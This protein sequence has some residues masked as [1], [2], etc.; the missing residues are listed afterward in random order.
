M[1]QTKPT[2]VPVLIIGA[3]PAGLS[4]AITLKKARPDL[5]VVV[6]DKAAGPG[7]HN[8]SGAVVEPAALG[9]LLDPVVPDWKDSDKAREVLVG[10]VEH[11]DLMFLLGEKRAFKILP[12]VKMAKA[13]GLGFGQLAH[14]GDFIC[15]ISKLTA[16]LHEIAVSAGVEVLHGFAAEDILWDEATH[17]ATGVTLVDQG[18]D[19]EGHGQPNYLPGETIT[20]DVILIAEGCDGLVAEKFIQKAGQIPPEDY[21]NYHKSCQEVEKSCRR[22]VSFRQK[23]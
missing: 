7:H 11:D 9:K 5:D 12:A 19:K 20:A 17:T 13:F 4:A 15:S 18:V 8:L 16:W 3:G 6:I 10:S 1:T 22:Y 2:H 23:R 14:D 21:P